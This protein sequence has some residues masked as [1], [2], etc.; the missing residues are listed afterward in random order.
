MFFRTDQT[1]C[2]DSGGNKISCDGTGQ[3]G[4]LRCGK[5]WP[6]PRFVADQAVV[7]DRLTGLMWSRDAAP[8]TF[9]VTWDEAFRAIDPLNRHSW[10]G[11]SDWRLPEYREL[12]S[13][14]SHRTLNPALPDPHPFEEVFSGYYWTATTCSRLP[15]EAWYVHVGGGRVFKG[16]KHGS[17]MLWPVR[18]NAPAGREFSDGPVAVPDTDASGT[19]DRTAP[20]ADSASRWKEGGDGTIKTLTDHVNRLTWCWHSELSAAPASWNEAHELACRLNGQATADCTDWHL[21][22]VREAVTL[23]D[24]RHHSPALPDPFRAVVS[25]Q[26]GFWTST[27]SAL[28]PRYAWVLYAQDGAVGVGYKIKPDFQVLVVRSTGLE[29]EDK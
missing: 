23:V 16:M 5:P 28:D 29:D 13:L 4:N 22:N 25:A 14:I 27:S 9:P 1:D 7:T 11:Y 8:E 6:E 3:D 21:P 18:T 17:Y 12:F 20:G 10:L 19:I 15:R 24:L 2:F 26:A